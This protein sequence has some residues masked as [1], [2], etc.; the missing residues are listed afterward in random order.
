MKSLLEY[1]ILEKEQSRKEPRENKEVKSLPTGYKK[2]ENSGGVSKLAQ[3]IIGT[4]TFKKAMLKAASQDGKKDIK[5][6]LDVTSTDL[7][8]FGTISKVAKANNDLSKLFD[9]KRIEKYDDD[10]IKIKIVEIISNLA[11]TQSSSER[12]IKFWM[13]STLMAYGAPWEDSKVIYSILSQG[14]PSIIIVKK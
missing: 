1:L 7:T 9:K 10:G 14:E 4:N 8:I 11:G 5:A 2:I 12:L 13:Q 3:D 6:K